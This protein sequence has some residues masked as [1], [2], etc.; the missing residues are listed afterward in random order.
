MQAIVI[1]PF[2]R[3]ASFWPVVFPDGDHAISQCWKIVRFQPFVIRGP[4]CDNEL[5]QGRTKFTFL[6]MY[7]SS[8][9]LGYCKSPGLVSVSESSVLNFQ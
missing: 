4:F 2:W 8:A 7:I 9:G 3:S 5:L 1:V 6:A